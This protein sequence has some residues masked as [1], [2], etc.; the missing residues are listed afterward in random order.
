MCS[1]TLVRNYPAMRAKMSET[2]SA[3][4]GARWRPPPWAFDVGFFAPESPR[5]PPSI[6]QEASLKIPLRRSQE[7]QEA[8]PANG[9]FPGL[10]RHPR[11]MADCES[12]TP[13]S[14]LTVDVRGLVSM[15]EDMVKRSRPSD[16]LDRGPSSA[17]CRL[18]LMH[19]HPQGS[20]IDRQAEL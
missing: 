16:R 3:A 17:D 12:H 8:R 1:L 14:N 5:A 7:P 4:R 9:A 2:N 19:V 6:P 18:R 20:R 11:E 15:R 13:P 10:D